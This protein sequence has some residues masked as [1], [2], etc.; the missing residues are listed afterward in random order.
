VNQLGTIA[1]KARNLY[2]YGRTFSDWDSIRNWHA[3]RNGQSCP[4]I[5]LVRVRALRGRQIALRCHSSDCSVFFDTFFA[6]YHVPPGSLNPKSV[7]DLGSNIGLTMAHF[8]AMYSSAKVLGVELDAHNVALCRRNIASFGD[9]C[10]ILCGAAWYENG[11]V[12]YS[13]TEAWGY[14]VDKSARQTIPAYSIHQLI[15]MMGGHV[16]YVK[17][18]I[19]GAERDVVRHGGWL[20]KIGSIKVEVHPPYTLGE[21]I[22]D[23]KEHGFACEIDKRHGASVFASR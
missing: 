23:L 10:Q 9:R 14:H 2:L 7:L 20:H 3:L 12:G 19:E 16:D 15:M 22:A 6:R 1:T 8:A 21:C 11:W 13:G 18:D 5:V 4:E 17:M